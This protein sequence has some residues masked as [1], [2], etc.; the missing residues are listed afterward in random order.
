MLIDETLQLL[1]RLENFGNSLQ[2]QSREEKKE[3]REVSFFINQKIK[4]SE[5]VAER[6]ADKTYAFV[7]ALVI[8]EV[9]SFTVSRS[10]FLNPLYA[11]LIYNRQQTSK[12][13]LKTRRTIFLQPILII[14]M[15]VVGLP[16]IIQEE[17]C[18]PFCRSL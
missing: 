14:K 11:A 3:K 8:I 7:D 17:Q 10:L 15:L 2:R 6:S 12:L 4:C 13:N 16:H 18:I 1:Q 9:P 5:V